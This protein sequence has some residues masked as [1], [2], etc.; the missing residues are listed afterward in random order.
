MRVVFLGSGPIGLPALKWLAMGGGEANCSLVGVV[1]Q[2]DRPVGRGLQ[3]RA[4]PIKE[5]A[6][7]LPVPIFQPE[8]LR[9][10]GAVADLAELGADLMVVVAYGQILSREVLALP[11]LGVINLH[12]SLLP[13][14]RG[15]SPIQAAILAGDAQSGMT[16]MHVVPEL[17]AGDIILQKSLDLAADETGGSL[18]DRLAELGAPA[19]AEAL[20]LLADGTAPRRAQDAALVTYA[21][22][23]SKEAGRMDWSLAAEKLER[24]VRAFNPWPG[25]FSILAHGDS[26]SERLL[27]KV[28]QAKRHQGMCG[29]EPGALVPSGSGRM[30]VA[31]GEGAL[32]VLE[33]Q[34]EG[35]KRLP[36]EDLLRGWKIPPG[37]KF[38]R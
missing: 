26:A 25:S 19:L 34:L 31:C 35:R 33:A 3:W 23:L 22:K 15:A 18:H 8:R 38:L 14:H 29:L 16:V 1:T 20:P 5:F 36:T 11:R 32:E 27:F 12:A 24:Q 7:T 17:D 37:A 2:P 21:G 10:A 9:E 28:W 6:Q 30:V 13:R 4:G